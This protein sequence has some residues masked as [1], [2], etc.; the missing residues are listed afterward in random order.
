MSVGETSDREAEELMLV[1]GGEG[2]PG[3]IGAHPLEAKQHLARVLEEVDGHYRVLAGGERLMASRARSCLLAPRAA[4]LV[5]VARSGPSRQ[6]SAWIIAVLDRREG[7][8]TLAFDGD[9]RVRSR[10]TITLAAA[11]G[12]DLVSRGRVRVA[13]DEL[14]VTARQAE[15]TVERASWIGQ[16]LTSRLEVIKVVA[17]VIDRVATRVSERARR[18]YRTTEEAEHWRAGQVDVKVDEALTTHAK[19]TVVTSENLVK[20]NGEQIHLG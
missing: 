11:E 10:G 16:V 4:D 19:N 13:S 5:L 7:D 20:L 18:V 9:L 14:K 6:A 3:E 17:G 12:V 1:P 8:C 15:A 2:S